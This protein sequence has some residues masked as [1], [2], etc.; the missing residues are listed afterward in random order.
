MFQTVVVP[1]DGSTR[2]RLALPAAAA[3]AAAGN[4][5]LRLVAV[6][7]HDG[8]F[9][10]SRDRLREAADS[11]PATA[12]T[13]LD[14]EL[15]DD[16]VAVLLD[17]ASDPA[18]VLCF[19][20]QV[21]THPVAELLGS[22]GSRLVE[23]TSYAFII[24]GPNGPSNATGSDV[25]VALDGRDDADPLLETAV[26]WA[27]HLGAP[28]RIVTVYEPV[29]P[30]IRR[31]DHYTRRHGP[32]GD[33]DSYLRAASR[34]ADDP[35]LPGVTTAAI[36]DPIEVGAGLA[37]HLAEDPALLLAVGGG[38][39]HRWASTLVRDLLRG[40]PPPVLVVPHPRSK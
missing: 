27:V 12:P 9:E 14:V 26:A 20:S 22:V 36:P 23:Q 5:G 6:A 13:A 25:V 19:E 28:L 10:S 8:E 16:P 38:S 4:A 32:P 30:D 17:L 15:G 18:N 37:G 3:I 2:S 33:P 31:P 29:P 35:R 7:R 21:H 1:I 24:V 40:T 39:R 34:R 11:L